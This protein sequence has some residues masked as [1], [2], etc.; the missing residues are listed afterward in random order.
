M[1]FL[2]RVK[3]VNILG[4]G[5]VAV[6]LGAPLAVW[7]NQSSVENTLKV[8]AVQ[9]LA[10]FGH[11]WAEVEVDG[12]SISASGIATSTTQIENANDVLSRI[13]VASEF[14]LNAELAP[15]LEPFSLKLSKDS[16]KP[17][18]GRRNAN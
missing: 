3:W 15:K 2:S 12:R 5:I 13:D 4:A 10:E 18:N 7:Q 17:F 1:G 8:Q 6:G 16:K 9:N 14:T 11:D